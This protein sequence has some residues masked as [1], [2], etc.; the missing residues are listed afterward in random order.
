MLVWL[1]RPNQGVEGSS[2]EEINKSYLCATDLAIKRNIAIDTVLIPY[3]R[4]MMGIWGIFCYKR[5]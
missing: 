4:D 2:Y 3:R 1:I 5:C